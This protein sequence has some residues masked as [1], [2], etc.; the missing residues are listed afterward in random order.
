[1][2]CYTGTK[3]NKRSHVILFFTFLC[4]FLMSVLPQPLERAD[5]SILDRPASARIELTNITHGETVYQPMLLVNG[6][7]GR[8]GEVSDFSV[9]VE[10]PDYPD[11]TWPCVDSY[12]K[13]LV[14][15]TAGP[16]RITFHLVDEKNNNERQLSHQLVVHYAPPSKHIPPLHLCIF[17]GRDSPGTFDVPP[18]KAHQNT[19]A[20][21][22]A[23][24]RLAGYLW[25]A[26]CA[27][28]MHRNGMGRRTFRLEET[29]QTDTVANDGQRRRPTAAVHVIRSRSTVA[30]IRDVRRAQQS[31]HRD[32]R[33]KD[34]FGL[35][36]DDLRDHPVVSGHPCCYVAGLILD[37][38]WDG[39]TVLGHAAL[40]GGDGAGTRLG[41][42]GSH[43]L[44]AWPQHIGEVVR[45]MMDTTPTDTRYVANDANESGEWW[46]ALNIGMGAMLHEVGHAFTLSH[47][48]SGIMSR[49]YNNWNRTFLAKEPGRQPIPPE[50]EGGSHWHRVD[51]IR[52]RYHPAFQ[53]PS[54]LP[55]RPQDDDGQGP[56]FMPL[57]ER[58][59]LVRSPGGLTLVEVILN[60]RYRTHHEYHDTHPLEMV[61]DIVSMANA[62]RFDLCKD[63][64]RL[65]VT[66]A[67]Q[68]T[69]AVDNV[70]EFL[71]SHVVMLPDMLTP[72]LKS[73]GFGN[74]GLGAESSYQVTFR[75]CQRIIGVCIH[76]GS[77]VDG[78]VFLFDDGSK[79][80]VGQCGGTRTHFPL[81]PDEH[82]AGMWVR[83]GAWVDGLQ[84]VTSQGRRSSWFGGTGGSLHW[85]SP[86]AQYKW[87]GVYGSAGRWLDQIGIYYAI[88][89][90]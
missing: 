50:D 38:H 26:F 33:V 46:R 64:V 57:S 66:T 53:L 21:A 24:L 29:W 35:F 48:A 87:M 72:V 16:N 22:T 79:A 39:N 11:T 55:I 44:H 81:H 5:P 88:I 6:R 2:P 90:P 20:V 62:L 54:D 36:L 82:L 31:P 68:C 65:E 25:Q 73:D 74:Q 78:V 30:E 86:P 63:K 8:R 19:L 10:T 13:A 67:N 4:I 70:L 59:I 80:I 42:F 34:L 58:T 77:F 71:E 76:H 83:S 7:A 12:F 75:D 28:Q 85:V 40:G 1:M 17:L 14:H 23:K 61:Y 84:L 47:S 43:L 27:E 60:G 41:I 18:Q 32:P 52:L 15:L 56:D 3:E 45:C 89:S 51:I 69:A 49:G 37:A 9:L